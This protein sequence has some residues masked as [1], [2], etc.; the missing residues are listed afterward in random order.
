MGKKD[1]THDSIVKTAARAFRKRGVAGVGVGD[2]M[3]EAGLTHGGFYAHF[4]SKNALIAE[5]ADRAASESIGHLARTV[6]HREPDQDP[7]RVLLETYLS[8]RHL[9]SPERGCLLASLGSD[10]QRETPDVRRV[11][12]RQIKA[13]LDLIRAQL[14]DPDAADATSRAMATLAGMVGAMI[15]GRAVDEPP[16]AQAML[17]ATADTLASQPA[18]AARTRRA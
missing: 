8:Q 3:K 10:L 17:T 4:P 16:M 9:H 11:A 18:T 12:T 15:I 14:P 5:A 1:I 2:L 6:E 7:L 13:L